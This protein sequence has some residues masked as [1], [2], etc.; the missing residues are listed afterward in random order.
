MRDSDL[1]AFPAPTEAD[2]SALADITWDKSTSPLSPRVLER[3]LNSEESQ[4]VSRAKPSVLPDFA[5]LEIGD[6]PPGRKR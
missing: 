2:N 6:D 1:S 3:P 5:S 4:S